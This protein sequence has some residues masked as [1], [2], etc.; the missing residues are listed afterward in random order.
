LVL[1]RS[2]AT[3]CQRD[4]QERNDKTDLGIHDSR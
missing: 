4:N 3:D 1:L 2:R